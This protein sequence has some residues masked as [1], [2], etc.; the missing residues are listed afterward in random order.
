MDSRGIFGLHNCLNP[1][2]V[3]ETGTANSVLS[4]LAWGFIWCALN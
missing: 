1:L 3:K 2:P 4:S